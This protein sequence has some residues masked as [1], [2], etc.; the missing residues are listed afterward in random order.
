MNE[1][2]ER[3]I[4]LWLLEQSGEADD[5]QRRELEGLLEADVAARDV[6]GELG[7]IC[8]RAGGM[9]ELDGPSDGVLEAIMDEAR[10]GQR[11]AGAR[12]LLV[13]LAGGLGRRWL[14]RAAA[15]VVLLGGLWLVGPWQQ[16]RS[17]YQGG[18]VSI[19]QAQVEALLMA[20]TGADDPMDVRGGTAL[21]DQL[22]EFQGFDPLD[23]FEEE[24]FR[25]LQ[26]ELSIAPQVRKT[27]GSPA[28]RCG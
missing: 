19:P 25:F 22:L 7:W 23:T 9:R 17:P 10:R 21:E 14:V 18:V 16:G 26:D 11:P 6:L 2:H 15:L 27:H 28:G 12:G 13:V 24:L 5:G 4:E 20:V 8:E 1:G 3:V